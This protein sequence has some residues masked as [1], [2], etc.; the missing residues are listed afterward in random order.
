M[1]VTRNVAVEDDVLFALRTWSNRQERSQQVR[2]GMSE[3]GGCFRALVMRLAQQPTTNPDTQVCASIRGT[4]FHSVLEQAYPPALTI[5]HGITAAV[6]LAVEYQGLLGHVDCYIEDDAAVCDFKTKDAKGM[7]SVR[8]YGPDRAHVQ[9]LHLYAAALLGA[10]KP[11]DKL[12]LV[13]VSVSSEDDVYCLQMPYE[14]AITDAAMARYREA[15]TRATIGDWPEPE[16][17]AGSWCAKF[18]RFFD[19]TGE[20]GC[21]GRTAKATEYLPTDPWDDGAPPAHAVADYVQ[22]MRL[23]KQGK[24]LKAA[25]RER[26]VGCRGVSGSHVVSWTNPEPR[27]VPDLEAAAAALVELGHEVPVTTRQ[28]SPVI[29]VKPLGKAS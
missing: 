10:G 17:D 8:N 24:E 14:Q 7:A 21:P 3:V 2:V 1:T 23:E 18:C 16:K 4:A 11:V 28:A 29:S 15:E 20:V 25:A 9:Q 26:L 19:A 13:Y 5:R 27:L 12:R 22:G 6:E